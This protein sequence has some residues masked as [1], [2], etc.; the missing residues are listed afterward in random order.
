[1][2]LLTATSS[3][4]LPPDLQLPYVIADWNNLGPYACLHV[5]QPGTQPTHDSAHNESKRHLRPY[6]ELES[7]AA[8]TLSHFW[9]LLTSTPRRTGA[10]APQSAGFQVSRNPSSAKLHTSVPA[11]PHH[12]P[13]DSPADH[14]HY[15]PEPTVQ[16]R[17]DLDGFAEE[18]SMSSA[19]SFASQRQH[20]HTDHAETE[21]DS[22]WDRYTQDSED[23][24]DSLRSNVRSLLI[25]HDCCYNLWA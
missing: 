5:I 16:S 13:N 15:R 19:S 4:E 8:E 18:G 25:W 20:S 10:A 17:P 3:S 6:C 2:A 7:G 14:R 12:A 23:E 9:S 21:T 24:D 22:E 1:M 11:R